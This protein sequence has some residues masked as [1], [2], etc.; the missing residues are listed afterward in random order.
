MTSVPSRRKFLETAAIT[1]A[2]VTIVP[3]HVLGGVGYQAPSDTFNVAGVFL[4]LTPVL[5]IAGL[6]WLLVRASHRPRS[7]RLAT[8]S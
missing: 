5:L 7:A 2:G 6:V 1:A 8:P 3:R 4:P